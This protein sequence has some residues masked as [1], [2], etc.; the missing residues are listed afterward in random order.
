MT[1]CAICCATV[2]VIKAV[3]MLIARNRRSLVVKTSVWVYSNGI[4]SMAIG[5]EV[6]RRGIIPIGDT[7]RVAAKTVV[8]STRTGV[9]AIQSVLCRSIREQYIGL[10]LISNSHAA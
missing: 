6:S 2:A 5:T 3:V 4:I 7:S 8:G 1:R 9:V 10:I